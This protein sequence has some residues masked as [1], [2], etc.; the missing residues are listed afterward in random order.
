MRNID[1]IIRG[2]SPERRAK[3]EGRA[4]QLIG[5]EMA[6]QQL[7]KARHLTQ[8]QMARALK[9]GQDSVSRLESRSDLLISTLRS[10]VEAMG[11][12]LKIVV[13]FKEGSAVI[14]GLT[15]A[16]P[17]ERPKAPM[18]KAPVRR[19]RHLELAHAK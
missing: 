14:S 18:R 15:A 1:H 16:E 3:I 13:E 4:R 7:R 9:I 17:P 10:Y 2:L 12:A 8:E 11:G 6:L 19:K 5:E